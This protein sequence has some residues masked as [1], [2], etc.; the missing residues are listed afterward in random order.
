M[1]L[2][3]EDMVDTLEYSGNCSKVVRSWNKL[4]I[5]GNDEEDLEIY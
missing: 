3:A 5:D 4:I 1:K 2:E